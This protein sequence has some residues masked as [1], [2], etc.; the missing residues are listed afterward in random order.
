[1]IASAMK[2]AH[3]EM[4]LEPD[5]AAATDDERGQLMQ[6]FSRARQHIMLC[7]RLKLTLWRRL[8]W[9]LWGL[10]HADPDIARGCGRRALALWKVAP[11]EV[12]HLYV[13]QCLCAPASI[14]RLQLDLFL[15][16]QPLEQLPYLL[17]FVARFYFTPVAER[18]VEALHALAKRHIGK[19]SSYSPVHMH[20]QTVVRRVSDMVLAEP[21]IL[22]QLSLCCSPMRNP[23]LVIENMGLSGHPVIRRLV[24]QQAGMRTELSRTQRQQVI[25]VLYHCDAYSLF[26]Q[27]PPIEPRRPD[28]TPPELADGEPDGPPMQPVPQTGSGCSHA[29][30][31]ETPA[32]AQSSRPAMATASG[33][34]MGT[35]SSEI[36]QLLVKYALRHL[37]QVFM[38]KR[39]FVFSLGPKLSPGATSCFSTA[40]M[41]ILDPGPL[42]LA[43]GFGF[44]APPAFG[45]QA[46]ERSATDP[47][48]SDLIVFS[49]T[50]EAVVNVK[51][52]TFAPRLQDG[53]ALVIARHPVVHI[54]T[55]KRQ[56]YIA[57]EALDG[58][59]IADFNVLTP[60]MMTVDDLDSLLAWDRPERVHYDLGIPEPEEEIRDAFQS[61]LSALVRAHASDDGSEDGTFTVAKES[62]ILDSHRRA[63]SYLEAHGMVRGSNRHTD[64]AFT[65]LAARSLQVRMRLQ[66]PSKALRPRSSEATDTST[67]FELMHFLQEDGWECRLKPAGRRQEGP[68]TPYLHSRVESQKIWWLRPGQSTVSSFYLRALLAAPEHGREVPH[69]RGDRHYQALLEGRDPPQRR[70]R[71]NGFAFC[72]GPQPQPDE[73]AVESDSS[74]GSSDTT[75]SSSTSTSSSTSS[76]SSSPVSS[77]IEQP[78]VSADEGHDAA[79]AGQAPDSEHEVVAPAVCRDQASVFWWHEH[80]FTP[81]FDKG[82]GHKGWEVVCGVH[83]GEAKRCTRTR[84]F[85]KFG[86]QDNVYS[87]LACWCSRARLFSSATE[88]K[89]ARDEEIYCL[90]SLE[91]IEAAHAQNE[92][93]AVGR[94]RRPKRR[95]T[96]KGP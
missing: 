41:D 26:R 7:L 29:A 46:H 67:V 76:S 81:V 34:D 3:G 59:G 15:A 75:S 42:E 24:E 82:G 35:N 79:L 5:I 93:L 32:A 66:C 86:G 63:L 44:Q 31:A 8:P 83:K 88:H 38:N 48:A 40:L 33:R 49:I 72:S 69:F 91:E 18:A 71:K 22:H 56:I 52:P 20:F 54:D 14:G 73:E 10:G 19:A 80:R 21:H 60:S 62:G 4:L 92:R 50:R 43:G 85:L 90:P 51:L 84:S 37:R 1:M 94:A 27:L 95:R 17:G 6:D 64:F 45:M 87:M 13:V 65:E 55:N 77:Q 89:A 12:K 36:N 16:G 57:L 78:G 47:P 2:V 96:S 9:L 74:S 23:S 28:P 68:A 53:E 11:A 61:V 39:L 58:Q 30:A 70:Q 25:D